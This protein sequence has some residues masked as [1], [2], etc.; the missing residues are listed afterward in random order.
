MEFGYMAI[1]WRDNGCNRYRVKTLRE[2]KRA[3][4]QATTG[5][6]KCGIWRTASVI[7]GIVERTRRAWQLRAN[8]ALVGNP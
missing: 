3:R 8:A 1:P 5:D 2:T 7:H 4:L 6:A